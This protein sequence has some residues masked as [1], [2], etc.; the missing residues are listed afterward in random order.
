MINRMAKAKA[1]E[2]IHVTFAGMGTRRKTQAEMD[3]VE[4]ASDDDRQWFDIH[5]L[6]RIRVREAWP[7]EFVADLGEPVPDGYRLV[8]AVELL[9][10]AVRAKKP[11]AYVPLAPGRTTLTPE[12]MAEIWQDYADD[13]RAIGTPV[14]LAGELYDR[15]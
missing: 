3:A 5:P 4:Q 13:R 1:H 15:K 11:L 12:Q 6:H 10:D 8:V 14:L 2:G 9:T 7:D